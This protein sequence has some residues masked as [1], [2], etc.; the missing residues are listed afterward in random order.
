MSVETWIDTGLH[1]VVAAQANTR[2][3]ATAPDPRAPVV[4]P[5]THP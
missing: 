3:R 1:D 5:G 4:P 2:G